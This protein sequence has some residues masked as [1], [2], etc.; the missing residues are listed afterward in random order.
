M[1]TIKMTQ[2]NHLRTTII[3]SYLN[4]IDENN[5]NIRGF[6]QLM[7]NQEQTLSRLLFENQNNLPVNFA[8]VPLF[9]TNSNSTLTQN[10]AQ[11]RNNINN[12]RNTN[13]SMNQINSRLLD[14]FRNP[15]LLRRTNETVPLTN[16][17]NILD[18]FFDPVLIAPSR[19]QIE[20]GTRI[21]LYSE[22]EE[23]QNTTC[24]ISLVQF[25]PE[26]EVIEILYC[27]H[28]Y[29]K[30]ELEYWFMHN[31]RCP[32]CRYDIRNYNPRQTNH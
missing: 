25:Q 18:S 15:G 24:P 32:L 22:L 3:N 21:I 30:N 26:S 4:Q 19:Q 7:N 28:L 20:N 27:H 9:S 10:I 6:T 2:R 5:N 14:I 8:T 11:A 13:N 16:I 12:T 31:S 23:P 29:M 1:L 17:D